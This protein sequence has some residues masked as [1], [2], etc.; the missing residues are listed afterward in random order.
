MGISGGRHDAEWKERRLWQYTNF[1]LIR[2]ISPKP[3][4]NTVHWLELSRSQKGVHIFNTV[5]GTKTLFLYKAI[6]CKSRFIST[7]DFFF[8]LHPERSIISFQGLPASRVRYRVDDVQF[9]YPASIFDVEE[10][11]GRVITRVNLNEEPTTIFKVSVA[12]SLWQH[13]DI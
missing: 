5:C 1:S 11:S 7:D 3:N 13:F 4:S 9:P 8:C 6:H 12:F 10:D 2:I